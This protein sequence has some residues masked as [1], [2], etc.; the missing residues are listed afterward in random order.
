MSDEAR[1]IVWI[2]AAFLVFGGLMGLLM[3]KSRVSFIVASVAAIPL[4]LVA[5]NVL[6]PVVALVEMAILGVYF[7]VKA[8]ARKKLMPGLPMS[9]I[10][11]LALGGLLGLSPDLWKQPAAATPPAEMDGTNVLES[12]PEVPRSTPSVVPPVVPES[13]PAEEILK[14]PPTTPPTPPPAVDP[15]L[16]S[17]PEPEAA[18]EAA[19]EEES[20][21][22][23][24][25]IEQEEEADPQDP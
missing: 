14:G 5:L 11:M 10:S 24:S 23:E 12:A 18:A 3:A 25:S 13:V 8:V 9:L 22:D 16:E 19:D 15:G 1:L 21:E 2:Y 20:S 7:G 6:P 17:E 4:A